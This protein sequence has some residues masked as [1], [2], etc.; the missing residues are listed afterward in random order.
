MPNVEVTIAQGRS[1]EQ[2][3][4]MMHEV[5]EAV[6]RTVDTQPEHIRVIVREVPRTHWAT[7]DLTIAEM[8]EQS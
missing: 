2:I 8:K 1:P 6:L 7:G 3:R 5:H 4:A